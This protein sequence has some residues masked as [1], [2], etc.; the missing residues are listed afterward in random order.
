MARAPRSP[1]QCRTILAGVVFEVDD[2]RASQSMRMRRGRVGGVAVVVLVGAEGL[3][4]TARSMLV[5]S[6]RRSKS[7]TAS[8]GASNQRDCAVPLGRWRGD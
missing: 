5:S 2:A 6:M 3:D 1:I 4:R 8:A 7:S